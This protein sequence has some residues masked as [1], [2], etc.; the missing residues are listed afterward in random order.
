MTLMLQRRATAPAPWNKPGGP[1]SDRHGNTERIDE[2][3]AS[4]PACTI[5]YSPTRA[6]NKK[7]LCPIPETV[8]TELWRSLQMQLRCVRIQIQLP[9]VI[10]KKDYN[11]P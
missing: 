9:V 6:E 8:R 3:V 4:K 10:L 5:W 7:R 2:L 11:E 1:L